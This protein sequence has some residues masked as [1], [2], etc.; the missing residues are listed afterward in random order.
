MSFVKGRDCSSDSRYLNEGDGRN[1]RHKG[2][3]SYKIKEKL[4]IYYIKE[5]KEFQRQEQKMNPITRFNNNIRMNEELTIRG[6]R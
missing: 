1:R 4:R 5:K 6:K 2:K 3:H